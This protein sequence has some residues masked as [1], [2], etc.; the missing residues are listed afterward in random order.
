MCDL[1]TRPQTNS[2]D[3]NLSY[4]LSPKDL[5]TRDTIWVLVLVLAR[6]FGCMQVN[7]LCGD[8]RSSDEDLALFLE[9]NWIQMQ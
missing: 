6:G 4:C 1:Q 2:R 3:S 8:L 7:S 9:G 5:V